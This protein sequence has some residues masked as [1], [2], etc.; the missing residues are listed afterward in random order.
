MDH[1]LAYTCQIFDVLKRMIL[2]E[3]IDDPVLEKVLYAS[4]LYSFHSYAFRR[5]AISF[6]A[7][8]GGVPGRGAILTDSSTI[9]IIGTI[10]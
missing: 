9:L 10:L 2:I 6:L 8:S 3:V 7:L 4:F 1:I 5:L